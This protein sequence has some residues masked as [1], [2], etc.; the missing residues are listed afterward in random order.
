MQG[1]GSEADE[2]EAEA[3][4]YRA[5]LSQ[6]M[7]QTVPLSCGEMVDELQASVTALNSSHDAPLIL[8]LEASNENPWGSIT[9]QVAV[10]GANL[11]EAVL[12]CK[13]AKRNALKRR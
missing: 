11:R 6:F 13:I 8:E 12:D 4:A 7:G 9:G 1:E 2:L 3:A 10:Q 5:E